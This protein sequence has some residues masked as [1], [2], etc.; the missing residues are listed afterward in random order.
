MQTY[1]QLIYTFK[2][3]DPL[4]HLQLKFYIYLRYKLL[5]NQQL[6]T[7][8]ASFSLRTSKL[9][10]IYMKYIREYQLFNT[11]IKKLIGFVLANK[12]TLEKVMV[13]EVDNY[14]HNK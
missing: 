7:L 2:K 1:N 3:N 10:T 4:H 6:K 5:P 12:N 14:T 9:L 8:F 11:T 13:I